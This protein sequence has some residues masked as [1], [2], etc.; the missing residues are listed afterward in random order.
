MTGPIRLGLFAGFD[1]SW[2]GGE[3]FLLNL[4][5]VIGR[6]PELAIVL[7]HSADA[8]P[9]RVARWQAAG[10]ATRPLPQLTRHRPAWWG[11]KLG[12]YLDLPWLD[13]LDRALQDQV[14]VTFLR[15][16]PCR[17]TSVPNVH[18]IPDFQERHL[19]EMFG[20]AERRSRER[21]HARFLAGS[22]LTIVQTQAAAVE[23]GGFLPMHAER[24][25]VLPF[26]VTIPPDALNADP[27]GVLAPNR[28]PERFVYFPGQLWRHKNHGLVIEALADVPDLTVVS[29]GHLVDYRAPSHV[30]DLRARIAMLG[31]ADRLRLLGPVS[32][33]TVMALHR[34]AMALLNPSR[35]EGWSTTVEEAKA[36]GRPLLLSDIR[37]H[38]EQAAASGAAWFGADDVAGLARVLVD[39]RDHGRPGPD[40]MAEAQALDAYQAARARFGMG[41]VR[42]LQEGVTA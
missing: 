7:F 21:E 23:L 14:D 31:L 11:R 5:Q 19:P 6:R 42:L 28:L 36:L 15:P 30:D 3:S 41:F 9:E 1:P 13:G 40:R 32:L 20:A 12:E 37:T 29:S 16:L 24:A 22:A 18:W 8:G 10:A 34:S 26:A 33:A 4:L 17:R 27:W 35:F 38:R 2:G 25:R 39:V